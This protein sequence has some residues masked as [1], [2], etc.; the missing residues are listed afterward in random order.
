MSE[1]AVVE[2]NA[3]EATTEVV[4]TPAS[5]DSQ[6]KYATLDAVIPAD[7]DDEDFRDKSLDEVLRIA[8]QHKHEI[9]VARKKNMEYNNLEGEVKVLKA[10]LDFLTRQQQQPKQ[11]MTREQMRQYSQAAPDQFVDERISPVLQEV[12]EMK[13]RLYRAETERVRERAGRLSG[14]DPEV[15]EDLKGPL[16]S[17]IYASQ[18]DASQEQTWI[19]AAEKYK[20]QAARLSPK[21]SVPTPAAPP[22]GQARSTST[23]KPSTPKFKS[24]A[25]EEMAKD[26]LKAQGIMPGS[27][28]YN[29]GLAKLA[30]YGAE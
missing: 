21:V 10:N 12:N 19:E 3:T 28:Y 30:K 5:T 26:M 24:A 16:A 14:I 15:W 9:G 17:I 20:K 13:S 8:K 7:Y 18:G 23:A 1:E 11:Q 4:E 27:K 25:D 6:K 22:A 2:T 29:E